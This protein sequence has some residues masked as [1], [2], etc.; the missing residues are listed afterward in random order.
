MKPAFS[1][2]LH[3]EDV[4]IVFSVNGILAGLPPKPERVEGV[5]R[6]VEPSRKATDPRFLSGPGD[7]LYSEES[8]RLHRRSLAKAALKPAFFQAYMMGLMP[9]LHMARDDVSR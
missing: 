5:D 8:G 2:I 6:V 9:E 7:P 3:R 1:M 4:S